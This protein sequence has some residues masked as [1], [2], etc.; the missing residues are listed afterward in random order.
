MT[1]A[2]KLSPRRPEGGA[3]LR[4][5]ETTWAPWCRYPL[6][7]DVPTIP[8]C[9]R[10]QDAGC[11][12][13]TPM[14]AGIIRGVC[15]T[16]RRCAAVP[17]SRLPCSR[18]DPGSRRPFW[19][20]FGGGRRVPPGVRLNLIGVPMPLYQ[21]SSVTISRC[22]VCGAAVASSTGSHRPRRHPIADQPESE[23]V[24]VL[25]GKGSAQQLGQ[26]DPVDV[27]LTVVGKVADRRRVPAVRAARTSCETARYCRWQ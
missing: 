22:A 11:R 21:S 7:R 13:H 6:R 3:S 16:P 19:A 4:Q 26:L 27:A 17:R 9:R 2:A 8:G 15:R 18:A 12:A 20:N 14:Q 23:F 24:A 5:Q 25:L 10:F 1:S